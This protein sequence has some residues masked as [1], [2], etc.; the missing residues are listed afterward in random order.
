MRRLV[1]IDAGMLY[2]DLATT[3]ARSGLGGFAGQRVVR[4]FERDQGESSG[5]PH[6]PRRRAQLLATLR[7]AERVVRRSCVAAV[8]AAGPIQSSLPGRCLPSPGWEEHLALAPKHSGRMW[9]GQP[10]RISTES[11][12]GFS[13]T[14]KAPFA[15]EN[16]RSVN[17]QAFKR[18]YGRVVMA[19]INR[20]V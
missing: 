3:G 4:L 16:E 7:P 13:V 10:Q 18:N 19:T 17:A 11:F 12:A 6:P 2:Q 5:I 9:C 20:K 1:G 8:A 14:I 15:S